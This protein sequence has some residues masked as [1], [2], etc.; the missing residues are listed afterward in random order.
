VS[1]DDSLQRY[2]AAA[3]AH[4]ELNVSW[5]SDGGASHGLSAAAARPAEG[6][7]AGPFP[8]NYEI[9]D[10]IAETQLS[11]TWKALDHDREA[12]VVI[13][14][15]RAN[16]LVD[17]RALERF[18]QEVQLVSKFTHPNIVPIL[19][20]HL[21]EPPLF[22]TMPLI[23]GAY[24]DVFCEEHRLAT[25][26]RLRLFLKVA[27]AITHAHQRGVIHRDLKPNNI[28]VDEDG[29][30]H[31]LD[32]GLGGLL[33][34][35]R[36]QED[37]QPGTVMGTATYM[38]PEQAAGLPGDTRSDVYSLGVILFQLLTGRLPIEPTGNVAEYLGRIRAEA[39]VDPLAA[40]PGLGRELAAILLRA[41]AKDP[42]QRYASVADLSR[43]IQAFLGSRPVSV[44]P[45][46]AWYVGS[47]WVRR[48]RRAVLLGSVALSGILG[49]SIYT[50]RLRW[51]AA[52]ARMEAAETRAWSAE[53]VAATAEEGRHK[54]AVAYGRAQ[55]MADNPV[56]AAATLLAEHRRSNSVRTRGA[57]WEFYRRYPC[58]YHVGREY[59]RQT[60][61][62]YSPD[63]RWLV[64]VQGEGSQAGRL[65]IYRA[66]TGEVVQVLPADQAQAT[67]IAFDP[68]GDHL[69]TGGS[70]GRI[71]AWV[72]LPP[73]GELNA[74]SAVDVA[75]L[76][77][78]I[79]AVAVS[80]DGLRVAAG[81]QQGQVSVWTRDA[82]RSANQTTWTNLGIV[83]DLAFSPDGS[84]LAAAMRLANPDDVRRGGV[85]AWDLRTGSELAH[86]PGQNCR[87]VRWA[88]D[89]GAVFIGYDTLRRW[90]LASG[91]ALPCGPTVPWGVRSLDLASG[92]NG[93]FI[94]VAGGDGRIRFYEARLGEWCPVSGF[95]ESAVADQVDVCFG[96]DGHRVAS[97]GPDGLRVWDFYPARVGRLP[98]P[99]ACHCRLT[100]FAV[101]PDGALVIGHCESD[102]STEPQDLPAP[103][104]NLAS[105]A[106]QSSEPMRRSLVCTREG[107]TWHLLAGQLRAGSLCPGAFLSPSRLV[108]GWYDSLEQ[109]TSLVVTDA[110]A[111]DLDQTGLRVA[112]CANAFCWLEG[113]P[114]VLL[115]GLKDGRLLAC[116]LDPGGPGQPHQV[117]VPHDQDTLGPLTSLTATR[118]SAFVGACW[119]GKGVSGRVIVWRARGSGG[120]DGTYEVYADFPASDYTWR[121]ALVRDRD[122]NLLAATGGGGG[123]DVYLWECPSGRLRAKLAGHHDVIRQ[124][125]ALNDRLLVTSSDDQTVR[126]WDVIEREE[127]CR[128]YAGTQPHPLIGAGAGRVAIVDGD[129][130]MIANASEVD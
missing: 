83:A 36:T 33:E 109:S 34:T 31:L 60:Q 24:L 121:L 25:P 22:Y 44:V 27:Q 106:T 102:L 105:V 97:V 9:I 89:G 52:Q 11:R 14:E 107:T 39:P 129:R 103:G 67:C 84:R 98:V 80:P 20:T 122:G 124:C 110:A 76:V 26:Q 57:L 112:G 91:V 13:K 30:P 115:I 120:F 128:L 15:P 90:D 100:P 88:E 42:G 113:A 78:P 56:I 35:V 99:H 117:R 123:R 23:E 101:S 1:P 87:A 70:D 43:D 104:A 61:V 12:Y 49:F 108:F 65:I 28:L 32:F 48:N 50:V 18:R 8:A 59:G 55:T 75:T 17:P 126:V 127:V 85:K 46:S 114:S 10:K 2:R 64:T 95:H 71:R 16:L 92:G 41:L 51:S 58:V 37:A 63:G 38:S 82:G 119:E 77:L 93:S 72:F 74:E 29:E 94:A 62:Q 21:A 54:L 130:L 111:P 19:A 5:P 96:P 6:D 66:E 86:Y 118:D 125:I 45:T 69:Y 116:T 68:Q 79:S 3:Q 7:A 53:E 47:R 40:S 81:S 73:T 4:P